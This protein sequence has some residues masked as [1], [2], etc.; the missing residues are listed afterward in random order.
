MNSLPS[1]LIAQRQNLAEMLALLDEEFSL[2]KQHQTLAL[3][4]VTERKQSLAL[5]IEALDRDIAVHPDVA[6]T[7]PQH[8]EL[9]DEVQQSLL[10]CHEKNAVNGK[11]LELLITANRRLAGVLTALRDRSS[12]TYDAKGNTRAGTRSRGIKA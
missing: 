2:L 4:D 1:L 11:F 8:Q 6:Q 7:L 10:A 12:L 5:R 3:P 9:V